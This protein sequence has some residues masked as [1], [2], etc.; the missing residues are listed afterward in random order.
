[1]S[2]WTM[3]SHQE[4]ASASS[5][6]FS[7]IPSTYTDLYILLSSRG[8]NPFV[9]IRFNGSGSNFSMRKIEGDGAN[10]AAAS[11]GDNFVGYASSTSNTA[12][13]FGNFGIYIPNYAGSR[14]KQFLAEGVGEN[15]GSAFQQLVS[16]LW[17][18][19]SAISSIELYSWNAT[20]FNQYSSATLYGIL[21]G[22][23]GITS[24]S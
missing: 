19:S 8:D 22:A 2:A 20:N 13:T 21:K 23:D 24:V 11:R 4:L 15:N 9:G 17:S 14:N 3:I 5:I 7:S 16:G 1:M 6:T 10:V 18:V 12:N